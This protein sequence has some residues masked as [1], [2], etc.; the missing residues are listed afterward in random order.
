MTAKIFKFTCVLTLLGAGLAFGADP[1]KDKASMPTIAVSGTGKI[2]AAPDVADISL[3]VVTEAKTAREALA[4]NNEAMASLHKALKQR[5]VADKDMQT[6]EIR[7]TPRHKRRNPTQDEGFTPQII[8]YEVANQVRI[9]ARDIPRMGPLLDAL[10]QVGANQIQGINFRIE[11]PEK[12]L[13]IAR[14][15]AIANAKRKAELYAGE[16]GVVVG[17]PILIREEGVIVPF[18][19]QQI[20]EREAAGEAAA[21][22]A[23]APIAPG[24]QELSVTVHVVYALEKPK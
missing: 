2:S 24:Q 3:G 1:D 16:A 13:D 20:E 9:T 22:M 4:A 17:A 23:P 18:F 15:Q 21:T 6:I 14:R 11:D 5:G 12:L 8:G 10:V 7:V 19:L